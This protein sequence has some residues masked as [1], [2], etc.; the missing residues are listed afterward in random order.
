MEV[1]GIVCRL[2]GRVGGLGSEV[3]KRV[4]G[5]HDTKVVLKCWKKGGKFR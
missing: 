5:V 1:Y 2:R 4:N 3:S